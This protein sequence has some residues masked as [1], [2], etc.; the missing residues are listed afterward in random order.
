MYCFLFTGK[1]NTT[2]TMK[3]SLIA[4]LVV[5]LAIGSESVSLVKREA[6][7]EFETIAKYFQDLADTFKAPEMANKAMAYFEERKAQF[8]PMVEKLQ[9]QLKPFSNIEEHIKPLAASVQSQVSPLSDMVQAQ[10]QD[11]IKFLAEKTKEILP[12]Q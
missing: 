7:A 3:V 4:L 11:M 9:E 8:Q 6:P 5:A 12:P 2:A 10:V 1:S